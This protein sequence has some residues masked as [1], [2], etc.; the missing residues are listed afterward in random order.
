MMNKN[1]TMS[2]INCRATGTGTGIW[3]LDCGMKLG[4][5]FFFI[6]F[7]FGLG[8]GMEEIAVVAEIKVLKK[9]KMCQATKRQS[10][11]EFGE[12]HS[13]NQAY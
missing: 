8:M 4:T 5:T 10:E 12:P 1:I 3:D 2:A 9:L 7:D 6:F 11:C 13:K